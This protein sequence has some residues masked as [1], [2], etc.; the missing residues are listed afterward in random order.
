M[1]VGAGPTVIEYFGRYTQRVFC[2]V[3]WLCLLLLS[4]LKRAIIEYQT[5]EVVSKLHDW[6]V[7]HVTF[8]LHRKGT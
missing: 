1:V 5:H 2:V 6:P 8:H 4:Q 7:R 3:L